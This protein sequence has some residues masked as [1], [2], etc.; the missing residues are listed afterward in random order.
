MAACGAVASGEGLGQSMG[1]RIPGNHA[2]YCLK[3]AITVLEST[4]LL[5]SCEERVCVRLPRTEQMTIAVQKK[6]RSE[7][8]KALC[9]KLWRQVYAARKGALP[10]NGGW[11]WLLRTASCR[12]KISH[13]LHLTTCFH[14]LSGPHEAQ[15][16][17]NVP[18]SVIRHLVIGWKDSVSRKWRYYVAQG[19]IYLAVRIIRYAYEHLMVS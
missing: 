5:W 12:S 16:C 1:K 19:I 3:V 18:R 14:S 4:G 7:Y 11:V 2:S 6:S 9:Q 13:S 10:P 17:F 8:A 15:A